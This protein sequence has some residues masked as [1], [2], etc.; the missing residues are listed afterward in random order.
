MKNSN[1][2]IGNRTR[3][4]PNCSAVPQPTAPPRTPFTV[5]YL[6][7]TMFLGYIKFQV[8]CFLS[9]LLFIKNSFHFIVRD[10]PAQ[11]NVKT[12][13]GSHAASYSLNTREF[14]HM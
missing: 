6:K 10:H 7:K 13:S 3:N 11:Q 14:P 1:D 5:T 9:F 2:T 12:C 4:L 8:F